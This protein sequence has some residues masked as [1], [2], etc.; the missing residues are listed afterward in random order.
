MEHLS[1]DYKVPMGPQVKLPSSVS[2][3]THFRDKPLE[4]RL[5]KFESLKSK[6][7][8][9][10]RIPIICELHSSS[11]LTLKS[12]LKFLVHEKMILKNFQTSVRRKMN[13]TEDTV[14]FFYH[15]KK[16]LQNSQSIGE[17]Y[18]SFRAKDGFLYIQFSE[19]NALG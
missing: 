17:L 6:S 13:F 18:S 5:K 19:I 8:N 10:D 15:N 3:R 1:N 16:I 2:S 7:G 12:D 11:Q 14:L 4:V 9:E